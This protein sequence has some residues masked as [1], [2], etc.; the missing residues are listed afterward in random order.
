MFNGSQIATW[1]R[2][3]RWTQ[4]SQQ[5]AI[6]LATLHARQRARSLTTYHC[7]SAPDELLGSA[8]YKTAPWYRQKWCGPVPCAEQRA[9][10]L[11]I[12]QCGP[13]SQ[14]DEPL[15]G[16]ARRP[17]HSE[18]G[19]AHLCAASLEARTKGFA[20]GSLCRHD[21]RQID[22]AKKHLERVIP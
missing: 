12:C 21:R 6:Q 9:K 8:S 7:A 18:A 10:K 17:E 22:M 13:R 5:C 11:A 15:A 16:G 19:G 20:D 1:Y 14:D 4:R 2:P 3:R